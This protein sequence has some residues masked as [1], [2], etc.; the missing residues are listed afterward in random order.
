[1]HQGKRWNHAHSATQEGGAY[2]DAPLRN[3]LACLRGHR[4]PL[5]SLLLPLRAL[6]G[7]CPD[8]MLKVHLSLKSN[9]CVDTLES[10]GEFVW[11]C[12]DEM[13]AFQ[14]GQVFVVVFFFNFSSCYY[15]PDDNFVD[16]HAYVTQLESFINQRQRKG[17]FLPPKEF[18]V[19]E[20]KSIYTGKT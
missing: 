7:E 8:K 3:G 1:M 13:G 19:P 2:M 14:S 12:P 15:S 17:L 4:T 9:V 20:L 6:G 5:G 10:R 18:L 11:V 16:R